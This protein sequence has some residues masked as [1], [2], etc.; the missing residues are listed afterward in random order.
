MPI[1]ISPGERMFIS[2][3]TN[4][5]KTTLVKHLLRSVPVYS[6]LDAKHTYRPPAEVAALVPI[7]AEHNPELPQEVIR[8]PW[9]EEPDGWG[10]AINQI[11]REGNRLIYVD[12][13]TLLVDSRGIKH[14]L[15]KAIRTG[16]ERGIG[17]WVGTQRP[18][19]IP[20]YVFTEAEHIISFQLQYKADRQKVIEYTGDSM[21]RILGRVRG[22]DAAYYSVANDR[23]ILLSPRLVARGSRAGRS[24]A[25]A[26]NHRLLGFRDDRARRDR[27]NQNPRPIYAA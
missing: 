25:D 3:R 12:E 15:G 2:G 1:V 7:V 26:G 14:P 18:K 9:E 23:A 5:G 4:S 21:A 27:G 10:D 8:I 24:S 20:S 13:A 11:F 22:H 16:R 19:D 6:V 17:V